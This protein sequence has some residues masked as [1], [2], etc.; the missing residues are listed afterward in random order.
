MDT[1]VS[2]DFQL[3][4]L[5][6][7]IDERRSIERGWKYTATCPQCGATFQLP[8]GTAMTR[9]ARPCGWSH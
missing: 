2:A 8:V 3:A 4:Q 7:E 6:R 9:G 1:T 5:G